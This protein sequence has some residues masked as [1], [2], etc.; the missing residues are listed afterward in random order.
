MVS[1]KGMK[2][3]GSYTSGSVDC[4]LADFR[5]GKSDLVNEWAWV[6]FT[7]LGDVIGLEFAFSGSQVGNVPKYVAM[8]DLNGAAPVPVPAAVWLLGSGLV[9]LLGASRRNA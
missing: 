8:D 5:D 2:D 7:S 4:Y 6:D 1:V 9:G 3:D